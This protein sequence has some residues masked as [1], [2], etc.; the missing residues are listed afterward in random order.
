[1]LTLKGSLT[2]QQKVMVHGKITVDSTYMCIAADG[3]VL[4]SFIIFDGCLPL[5]NFKDGVLNN[6]LYGS[7]ESG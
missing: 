3:H 6:W 1:M 2:Y 7:S 4:P 5:R